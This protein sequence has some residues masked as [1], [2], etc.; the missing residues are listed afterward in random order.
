MSAVDVLAVIDF[1][2]DGWE[3]GS[4]PY[5]NLRRARAAVA[6]LMGAAENALGNLTTCGTPRPIKGKERAH[7]MLTAALARCSGEGG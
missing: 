6:E 7:A 1:E 2:M 5:E 4:E 3:D